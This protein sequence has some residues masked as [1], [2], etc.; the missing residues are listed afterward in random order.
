MNAPI[1][2]SV[3]PI[4]IKNISILLKDH[5]LMFFVIVFFPVVK[6]NAFWEKAV[7][8]KINPV[9]SHN[10]E[11]LK[12]LNKPKNLFDKDVFSTSTPNEFVPKVTPNIIAKTINTCMLIEIKF[13]SSLFLLAN[14][15]P[16]I[17]ATMDIKL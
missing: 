17:T 8:I 2:I 5:S 3:N 14:K 6:T 4:R 16:I 13:S 1:I 9:V 15:L 11:Y 12:M 10:A 7:A